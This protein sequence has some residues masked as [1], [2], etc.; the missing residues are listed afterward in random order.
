MSTNPA[1]TT[2]RITRDGADRLLFLCHGWSAEQH[3]LAAYVPLVDPGERFSAVC[4]RAPHDLPEGDGASWYERSPDGPDPTSFSVAL[5]AL[6]SL[7]ESEMAVT[8]IGPEHTVV[9][10]FSQGG[11]LALALAL[12]SGA[13][14]YAGVWAMCCAF[15]EVAGLDVDPAAASGTP[16]LVQYG[17]HDG[18]IAPGRTRQA[19]DRLSDAGWD[20]TLAGYDM[21]HSQRLEMMADARDW[22][23]A[24]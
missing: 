24:R 23:S 12:R 6:V 15:P 3:H 22:L 1:L 19:A 4:P 21:A 8:G 18:I 14:R 20:V 9:G 13:P 7:T 17:E 5:D 2:Y 16:A 10:G 11:F